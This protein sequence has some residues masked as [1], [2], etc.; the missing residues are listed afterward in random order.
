MKSRTLIVT[1]FVA[2]TLLVSA[3][4]PAATPTTQPPTAMAA[5]TQAP[6]AT[7]MSGASSVTSMPAATSTSAPAAT[8]TSASAM[9][10][11]VTVNVGKNSKYSAFLVDGKGMTLYIFTKDSPGTSTCNGSCATAWPPLLTNGTPVAGQGVNASKFG[12]FKRADGT[13]QVTYNGWPLYYYAKDQQPGDTTGDGVGSVWYL[14][15]PS[16]DKAVSSGY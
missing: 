7:A 12:M 16:G 14:I 6:A 10:G 4:A 11:A 15:T 9:A 3:C 1:T 13:T 5:V 8:S 2:L